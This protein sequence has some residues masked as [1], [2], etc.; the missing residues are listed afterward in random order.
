MLLHVASNLLLQSLEL[1]VLLREFFLLG[2]EH[3]DHVKPYLNLLLFGEFVLVMGPLAGRALKFLLR[4]Q[5]RIESP[6]VVTV[7]HAG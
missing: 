6:R 3:G 7:A 1:V 5:K 2:L 4:L